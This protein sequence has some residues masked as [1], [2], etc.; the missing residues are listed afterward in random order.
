M[1]SQVTPRGMYLQHFGLRAAPFG[2]TPD[3]LFFYP[4]NTRGELL[5]ALLAMLAPAAALLWQ[6]AL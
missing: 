3:P 4:G 2:I 6:S 5:A 1:N